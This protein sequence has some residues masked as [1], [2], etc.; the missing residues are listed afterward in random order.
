MFR[1]RAAIN[2][3]PQPYYV[4][5]NDRRYTRADIYADAAEGEWGGIISNLAH[6]SPRA[7]YIR[8]HLSPPNPI[9]VELRGVADKHG[10]STDEVVGL[11]ESFLKN[12]RLYLTRLRIK[13][14]KAQ[15]IHARRALMLLRAVNE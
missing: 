15:S 9:L 14:T 5:E 7:E 10:M 4:E 13:A 8:T 11:A 2:D 1:S 12:E 6:N 3:D